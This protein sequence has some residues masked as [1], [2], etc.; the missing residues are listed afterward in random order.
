[1]SRGCWNTGQMNLLC[2]KG[3]RTGPTLDINSLYRGKVVMAV[4]SL[5]TME[6]MK[7]GGIFRIEKI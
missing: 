1:M 4:D 3:S 6:Q 2:F 7:N 5:L